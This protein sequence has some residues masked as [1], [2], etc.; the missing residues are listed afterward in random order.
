[1]KIPMIS[2]EKQNKIINFLDKLYENKKIKIQDT[3]N[4]YEN[5]NLFKL[6]LDE[7]YEIFEKLIEWQEQS[8]ELSKQIE[9]FKNRLVRYLFLNTCSYEIKKIKSICSNIK[10]G[11]N[12]PSDNKKGTLYPYYGTG[13]ITGYTDDF[14]VD[15]DYI[16][17]ARNGTIGQTILIS[18]KSFPSDHMFIIKDTTENIKYIYLV[19]N[20]LGKLTEFAHGATIQGITKENLN[21]LKIPIPPLNI[22]EEII[23]YYNYNDKIIKQLEKE[24]DENKKMSKIFISNIINNELNE[25]PNEEPNE[26]TNE[27]P[28]KETNEE[29][30][31][32]T[33]DETNDEI[34]IIILKNKEYYLINNEVYTIKDNNKDKLYGYYKNNKVKKI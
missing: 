34:Q 33:N 18:G 3:I 14:L 11:K 31:E 5:N 26:E 20:Y 24:I 25:E 2:I 27:E 10:T 13:G 28:N 9:F 12:K 17:T 15:G 29:I 7:K 21:N 19:I 1:M 30:N 16:L 23:K 6:L 22:Q 4:Y 32:E 8:L